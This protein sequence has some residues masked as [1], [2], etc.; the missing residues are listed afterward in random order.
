MRLL[1]RLDITGRIE[2]F[3]SKPPS[4]GEAEVA[5]ALALSLEYFFT[6]WSSGVVLQSLMNLTSQ[7]IRP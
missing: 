3:R 7:P 5:T 6:S 4:V 2:L 1:W